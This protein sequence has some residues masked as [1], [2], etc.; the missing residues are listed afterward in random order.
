MAS[1]EWNSKIVTENQAI[2]YVD[3]TVS[4]QIQTSHLFAQLHG[5]NEKTYFECS[6]QS[7]GKL[8]GSRLIF[9]GN[10]FK[11][12]LSHSPRWLTRNSWWNCNL[13]TVLLNKSS[14]TEFIQSIN[15]KFITNCGMSIYN[16]IKQ[17]NCWWNCDIPI[18]SLSYFFRFR[19]PKMGGGKVLSFS[20]L[21]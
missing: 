3:F 20:S 2:L 4:L 7:R 11:Q 14:I 13:V 18:S 1:F 19:I 8:I 9:D 6:T 10:P 16:V 5:H 15:A 12:L 17:I 21:Y